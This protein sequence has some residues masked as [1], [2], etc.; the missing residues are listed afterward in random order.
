MCNHQIIEHMHNSFNSRLQRQCKFR[1]NDMIN[2]HFF[3]TMLSVET[4]S[5][6]CSYA[7]VLSITY[8]YLHVC[9]N[10]SVLLVIKSAHNLG[11]II[12]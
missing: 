1:P 7:C 8:L 12:I 3:T 2:A 6:S 10:T 11:T 5:V 9:I 4:R